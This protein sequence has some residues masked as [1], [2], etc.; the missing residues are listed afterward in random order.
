CQRLLAAA[1][2]LRILATSREP[3]RI[4]GEAVWPV[5]PLPVAASSPP[6]PN[7]PDCEHAPDAAR[8][9]TERAVAALPTF[10]V[11]AEVARQITELCAALDGIPLA[12]ELAAA[13]VRTLSVEQIS[14]R[15]A[16]RFGL[17]TT[18]DRTAP[19]RQQTLRAA[20]DWSHDLLTGPEQ[21]L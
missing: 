3:L 4:A 2:H 12:I 15:L 21:V 14:G 11:S 9:F 19:R 8:L 10:T 18:G 17:L 16:D 13:R 6:D 20:I 5:P 7:A 1:P